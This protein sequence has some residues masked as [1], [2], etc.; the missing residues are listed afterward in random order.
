MAGLLGFLSLPAQDSTRLPSGPVWDLAACL[1]Y[2]KAH[3]ITL[4]SLRLTSKSGE[5]D[6]I[7]SRTAR[8]PNLG[9]SVSQSLTNYSSGP[10]SGRFP[11]SGY[12]ISSSVTLYNGGYLNNDI[13][14]KQ[15][16]LTAANLD[17][18]AAENDITLQITQAY[19]NIL[20]A[21]ENIVYLQDLIN[22][23]QAQV[24][25]GQQRF[26]AGTLAQKDLLELKAV[27]ANDQ[28]TLVTAQNTV[29]QNILTLK[30]VLQL[31]TDTTFDVSPVLQTKTL[32]APLAQAQQ[33]ALDSRPEVKSSELGVQV[34]EVNI[35][36][37]RAG[38][39]PALT[40]GGSLNTGYSK[41]PAYKYFP[42][43]NNN[44]YQQLGLTL[45]IPILD[46]KVTRTNVEKARIQTDQAKLEL[47]NTKLVLTQ[48]I[49]QA[50]L[51]AQNAQGQYNAAVVQLGYTQEAYRIAN[52][53][54]KIG[55]YNTVEYLQQKNLYIQ[56]L[57]SYVQ[58]KYASELYTRI[59]NF[60]IGV[61]VTQ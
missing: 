3:N 21:K 36:K 33:T 43:L 57:Q 9:G 15:L 50:W 26:D 38:L 47:Q 52:E 18:Q 58:A 39:R 22:T 20:L 28:Y 53:Q 54:L 23:T 45:S 44:F 30:Q 4:G 2:A 24:T 49:E 37:A 55:V 29:R 14:Q 34:A 56:A 17:V 60:Y 7:Q 27:L 42:Q 6:L 61:P 32:A 12:G 16:S 59:Y 25:Q 46:R 41:D 8:Y 48:A 13:K 40:A 51:N 11:S 35:E 5:Q 19:L 31:P 10:N 1:A